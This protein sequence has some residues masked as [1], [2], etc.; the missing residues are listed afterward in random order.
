LSS[1]RG[2]EF[3]EMEVLREAEKQGH[4]VVQY[5]DDLGVREAEI[6]EPEEREEGPEEEPED[7]FSIL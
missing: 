7:D 3:R 4:L 1:V 2:A 6:K 5:E